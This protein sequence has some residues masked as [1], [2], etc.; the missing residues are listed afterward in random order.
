MTL[1]RHSSRRLP[2]LKMLLAALAAVLLIASPAGAARRAAAPR[3]PAGFIGTV[4]GEPLFPD[5]SASSTFSRQLDSMVASGV[6]SVRAVFD[7]SVAQPYANWGQVPDDQRSRFSTDGVDDVPTDFTAFDALVAAAARRHVSVLPIVISA[8][9][10]DGQTFKGGMLAIP[11]HDAPYAAFCAALARRYGSHGTF[12][13]GVGHPRPVTA[14]QIW[15]EPNVPAFWPAGH[16]APRYVGL[17]RAAHAA[18]KGADPH[19]KIV[20]AGLANY[21]WRGLRAI[22]QLRGARHLF[23]VVGLH[24]YTRTPQGVV[25]ILGYARRV[26]R[27]YGDGAKPII[28]DEISWPSSQGKTI[29]DNGYDFATTERGQ[30]RMI[31]QALPLLAANRTRLGL[32]AVYYYTWVSIEDPH[33]YAFGYSGLLKYRDGTFVRK[34]ALG[35]FRHAALALERCRAKGATADRCRRPY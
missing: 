12:W 2:A 30:A 25:T 3:V 26:M 10:W 7:W 4:V 9:G 23:D 8:P 6:E 28:A 11:R 35:A 31:A 20:L 34:P 24:P 13:R 16:F 33:G 27:R 19:A 17:L 29:H 18:I 15:N 21:S 22:Y 1:I 14:W 32:A 5:L